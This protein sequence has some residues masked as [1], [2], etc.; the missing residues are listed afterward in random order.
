VNTRQ[1]GRGLSPA[2]QVRIGI[3]GWRYPPWRSVFYP[4]GLPQRAE[5]EYAA[6]IFTSIE[7][8]GSFYSLQRPECY[9]RWYR[10]TPAR[11]VFAVKGPRFITHM[12]KLRNCE[13]A[14]AN[15]LASG[16][17]NLHDKLGPILWQLPPN[18]GYDVGRLEPFL[19]S[20]PQDGAQALRLA[21]KRSRWMK[22]RVRLSFDPHMRIRHALEFRHASFMQPS[23][24]ELLS[25][26]GIALV[27]ADTA[28]KWPQ[29]HDVTADFVYVRLHGETELYRSGY[30]NKALS[31][32][33]KRIAAWHA[34]REPPDALKIVRERDP[35]AGKRDVY[36]FFDNTDAKLRAPFDAQKLMVELGLE[37]GRPESPP[38][39]S[40]EQ[41]AHLGNRMRGE[42]LRH[43]RD[44]AL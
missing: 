14:L 24:V 6:S 15:F 4:E 18:L 30:S 43:L 8:N 22:G 35:S 12:L 11:F 37:V 25:R 33:A 38:S 3:S 42:V 41:A 39:D 31:R 16:I 23:L 17:F 5:L 10:Q 27:V 2:P 21:R 26:Y 1:A 28:G 36:C 44:H 19:A 32:W 34:G 13:Q 20:L 7:I 40:T 29:A 9:S